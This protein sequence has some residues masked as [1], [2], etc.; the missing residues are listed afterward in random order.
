MVFFPSLC[1][2]AERTVPN[3]RH[4]RFG[5]NRGDLREGGWCPHRCP[6]APLQGRD[7]WRRQ[8]N[9][10][11]VFPGGVASSLVPIFQLSWIAS[12]V[13][14]TVIQ[15]FLISYRRAERMRQILGEKKRR[16][17]AAASVW[18][19]A[20]RRGLFSLQIPSEAQKQVSLPIPFCFQM[21]RLLIKT[22]P[23]VVIPSCLLCSLW[24][25]SAPAEVLP[26]RN[27][28]K[29]FRLHGYSW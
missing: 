4:G 16:A 21:L 11:Q 19:K 8:S 27:P 5:L 2:L 23:L 9:E 17:K 22:V 29:S 14:L 13:L 24:F 28:P 1:I 15:T 25:S 6:A 10:V 12:V 26:I 20:N 7:F 3:P 18:D